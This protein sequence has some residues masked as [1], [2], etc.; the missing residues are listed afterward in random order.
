[1]FKQISKLMIVLLLL[2]HSMFALHAQ[3][4]IE[5]LDAA[6]SPL[7]ALGKGI[8]TTEK[9]II[10]NTF[11]D[12]LSRFYQLR[13]QK[14]FND[15][16]RKFFEETEAELCTE[17]RCIQS[18]QEALQLDRIF[19]LSIIRE[20]DLTQISIGLTRGEDKFLK[21]ASCLK[22]SIPQM[23]QRLEQ[24][25]VAVVR[26]DFGQQQLDKMLAATRPVAPV[27]G[28]DKEEEGG[29]SIW[30]W[31]LGGLGAIALLAGSSS[32]ESSSSSSG[33]GSSS[34]GG[35]VGFTW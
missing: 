19:N 15:A 25:V 10:M 17:E 7:T 16:A 35:T 30:W 33:S 18:V 14:E 8:K 34:S 3:E 6:T 12:N 23:Q 9:A 21:E 20:G 32:D 29:I 26:D 28:V 2:P 1:M 4:V 31:I 22:C 5:K 11:R 27:G 13:S 24:L